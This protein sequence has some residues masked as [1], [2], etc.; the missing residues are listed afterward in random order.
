MNLLD[1]L[2]EGFSFSGI[3]SFEF[4]QRNKQT[5]ELSDKIIE[6]FLLLPPEEYSINEGYKVTITKTISDSWVDDF[7]NDIKTIKISGSLYAYYTGTIYNSEKVPVSTGISGLDEFFKLRYIFSRFRDSSGNSADSNLKSVFPDLN[8]LTSIL[9]NNKGNYEDVGIVYH[10]YDD[11]NHFEVI[12]TDFQMSKNK[13]DPWTINYSLEMKALKPYNSSE[14]TK[15]LRKKETMSNI[16]NFVEEQLSLILEKLDSIVNLPNNLNEDYNSIITTT[17]TMF[18]TVSNFGDVTIDNYLKLVISADQQIGNLK[19]FSYNIVKLNFVEKTGE[20]IEEIIDK[21]KKEEDGYSID[22]PSTINLLSIISEEQVLL[23]CLQ[24]SDKL[25]DSIQK[26]EIVSGNNVVTTEQFENNIDGNVKKYDNVERGNI[27][28]DYIYYEIKQGDNLQN[29][30]NKFYGDYSQ[31]TLISN[32]NNVKNEDFFSDK[33]IGKN[34]KIPLQNTK[35]SKTISYNLIYYKK[36][37][38]TTF[39]ERQKQFLGFDLNL[40][41]NREF[42]IDSSGDFSMVFGNDCYLSNIED[43][44]KYKKGTLNP[45]HPLWGVDIFVGECPS[46]LILS[47]LLDNIVSQVLSDPRTDFCYVN[48]KDIGINTDKISINL[49]YKTKVGMET[50]VDIGNLVS[51]FI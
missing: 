39:L 42:V 11:N 8:S 26:K 40:D 33:M 47:K 27:Y 2:S 14:M 18:D 7:G 37:D 5:S 34:I 38:I 9:G 12:F 3:Y 49:R 48:K 29:L 32:A 31:Y 24:M 19:T 28:K 41:S 45:I 4:F 51:S 15:N 21:Y 17:N 6:I 1:V 43:R 35:N 50:V 46:S 44:I 30:S 23:S 25:L 20:N 36:I 10:D 22:D 13:T 16:M